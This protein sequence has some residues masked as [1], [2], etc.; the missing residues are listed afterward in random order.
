MMVM[1]SLDVLRV[2]RM[3]RAAIVGV[4]RGALASARSI[5]ADR[6]VDSVCG[7]LQ[8]GRGARR[9]DHGGSGRARA[10]RGPISQAHALIGSGRRQMMLAN[11]IETNHSQGVMVA[12]RGWLVIAGSG[13]RCGCSRR[14]LLL[15]L[16]ELAACITTAAGR[17]A[18]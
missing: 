7:R 1:M 9:M 10:A 4:T 8:G 3:M 14:L 15:L 12:C 2:M 6:D 16:L 18:H 11:H 5:D 13:G 17:I